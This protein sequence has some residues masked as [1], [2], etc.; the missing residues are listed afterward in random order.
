MRPLASWVVGRQIGPHCE[1]DQD[2]TSPHSLLI[3]GPLTK[4][5]PPAWHNLSPVERRR[6]THFMRMLLEVPVGAFMPNFWNQGLGFAPTSSEPFE[7]QVVQAALTHRQMMFPEFARH[8]IR[9]QN[10]SPRAMMS[11]TRGR[12][13]DQPIGNPSNPSV[14]GTWPRRFRRREPHS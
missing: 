1:R 6:L 5:P 2:P 10:L 8:Q 3:H 9:V 12:F 4:G 7:D 14:G 13:P 11:C